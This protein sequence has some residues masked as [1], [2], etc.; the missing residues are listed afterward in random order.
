ML[1]YA[2]SSNVR[3]VL[4]NRR[5]YPGSTGVSDSELAYLE[6][7]GS[8][9]TEDYD[10]N[11]AMEAQSNFLKARGFEVAE[12]MAWFAETEGIPKII[13]KRDGTKEGGIVIVAWSSGNTTSLS[14]FAHLRE[15]RREVR[16]ALEPYMRNYIFYGALTPPSVEIDSGTCINFELKLKYTRLTWPMVMGVS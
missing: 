6:A 1:P 7:I 16:E 11:K 3:I 10:K 12:F 8:P 14:L 2:A 9:S 13:H 15:L 4:L 5:D